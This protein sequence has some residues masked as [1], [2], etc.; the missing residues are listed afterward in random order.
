MK[1]IDEVKARCI[2][3]AV[4]RC[5]NWN[6][7]ANKIGQPKIYCIDYEQ[8][9]MRTMSGPRGVWMLAHEKA[10]T[11]GYLIFRSCM[12]RR[13]MNPVHLT[14]MKSQTE[15]GEHVRI[16]GTRKG[17]EK[18]S[19]VQLASSRRVG[20]EYL[21][22][23]GVTPAH[24]VDAVRASDTN[25]DN[26]QVAEMYGIGHWTVSRIRLGQRHNMEPA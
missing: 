8:N 24:I 16:S 2:V 17:R 14:Q 21:S 18:R 25:L 13:C 19:E 12:N 20:A 5:W 9:T 26:H 3:D 22:K 11:R 15:I 1:S 7:A 23:H 10:P 4:T 6:G